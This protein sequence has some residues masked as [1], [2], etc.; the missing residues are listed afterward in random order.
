MHVHAGAVVADDGFGH[1]GRSLA[2][3]VRDIVHHIFQFCVWSARFT[4]VRS[5]CRFALS[6]SRH[7]FD[8]L[9]RDADLFQRQAHGGADVCSESTGG[10]REIAALTVGGGRCC[11]HRIFRRRT[12]QLLRNSPWQKQRTCPL[13]SS[14]NQK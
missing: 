14:P 3:L 5:G 11:R 9:R 8:A 1:E 12:K 4:S 13:A 7:S 6:G 10:T 2:I